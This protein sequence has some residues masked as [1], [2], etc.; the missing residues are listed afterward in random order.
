MH[1]SRRQRSIFFAA[2]WALALII[3]SGPLFA[4]APTGTI[5]G[6]ITDRN[7]SI[8]A[9]AHISL[10]SRATGVHR[11]LAGTA[12]GRFRFSALP[13]GE[14]SITIDSTG[15]APFLEDA[16]QLTV[17]GTIRIDA[18]VVPATLQQ[19]V[20]VHAGTE[21]IDLATNT[22]GKTVT[23]REIVDLPLNGRN[24]AQLG[25]LQTGVAP[26]TSGLLTEGG[27]LRAGQSYVVNGQRPEANNFI[28]DGAQNVDRMDG[29]FAL[30]IPID[31][32]QEFRILTATAS[33]EY[34]GNIGSITTIVTKSGTPH[35][36]GTVYEF[37]RNDI[38][39]TRNYFSQGVE[40][41][42]QNQYGVTVGGPALGKRLFFFSY[43]EGLRNRAG[44]TTSAT[45][46]TAAQQAG[47]FSANAT[48]L[49]NFAAGGTP[50]PGG[51]LPAGALSPVGLNVARFYYAGNTSPSVYTST[52]V[53]TNN[54]DQTGL[55]LDLHHTDADSY[56]LRYSYFTG[57]NLNPISV[58]GSDLPGFPTRDDYAVHSAV[59]G[60]THLFGA[61]MS[62]NVQTSF[63]RY[64]FL[65]DQRLNQNG[66]RTLGF[67]Y[68]SASAIGQGPPFFNL[69]GYSPVGGAITGPR[70]SVQNTYE[71]SDTLSLSHGSHLLRFGGDFVRNQFNLFQS[72][73]PNG[74][75]VF[76]SSFPTNDAF[77]NLL[78]GAPVLFYQGLGS[79]DRGVRHWGLAAFAT[80]EYRVAPRL[81]INAGLRYEIINPNTEI[82]DRLNA[83][84]PGQQSTKHPEAPVGLLYPGDTG[85]GKGIA[86]TDYLGFGPRVGFAW[87]TFG[88]GKTSIRAAYGIFYD[89][90]SNG[91]NVTAQGPISSLPYAQ[92]VQ[93][94]GQVNFAAPYTGRTVPQPNTFTQPATAFTM[95]PRATPSNA[96]DWNLGIQQ[97]LGAAFVL[98][99]RYVGTKGTHLPRNI[100]ANPAVFGPGAT[101]SNADRRRQY[102][103][104]RPNNGPCDFATVGELTYGQNSTYHAAQVSVSRSFQ[105]GIGMNVS[106]WWS[107]TLDYLSSMNLQ[108][109][110]AKPLSGENDLAQNP[111]N[112]KGEH[113]P[114]LFDARNRFVAS[115]IWQV[116]FASHTT[117]LTRV[118]LNG[119]QLN[120][121][122]VANSPTPFTVYDSTNVSL[123][124]SSPPISGYF[125]SRPNLIGNPNQGPHTVAQWISP[126]AFQRLNPATQAGQFGNSGRNVARAPA[127]TNVDASAVKDFLLHETTSLQFRAEMFNVAN[128]ANF[129]V[130]IAD[131]ASPNF[132]RVLQSGSPRLMQFAAKILF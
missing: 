6:T 27:S 78:L 117:G 28:L 4:Q 123:Q 22:L 20:V 9:N 103:N 72:V 37:F 110:S 99:A 41:L 47:D 53:G 97:D 122:A 12:N 90:F 120:A 107:K 70:T 65:F 26:L 19:S 94:S 106:Y 59:I 55:R 132:G 80:D 17:D 131:L 34:G 24:F 43:Y 46:P 113:G 7:G 58:R 79:F 89:P 67:N 44:I 63:F 14:Y 124:A 32:L 125:A 85:I 76:A 36:H 128:H 54:Y 84:V 101:S 40:P 49:L 23:Q 92:F 75:F 5:E 102:A 68:D 57:F 25:L 33:P 81:T 64:G 48:P 56:F 112:L 45:V 69:S 91:S 71:V 77:A 16:I 109:A 121:I 105:H 8:V 86:K 111:F 31:A 115:V 95:D 108:G 15:F 73:A 129:G 87:D 74:F 52:L 30:R 29:G 82:H 62:N 38:L 13:V 3:A 50:F 60:N 88:T 35:Y 42:K 118:L 39:D 126:S 119:W 18:V 21:N 1:S 66:P 96:Q 10:V 100:E 61:H 127:F 98:E 93:I 51:K 114:S 116:P 104:C 130:P 11:E 83:F 2:I